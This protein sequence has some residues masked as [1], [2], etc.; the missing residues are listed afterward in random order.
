MFEFQSV[1][2]MVSTRG[3]AFG[4]GS[5][6]GDEPIDERLYEFITSEITHGIMEATTMIFGTIN[7]GIM[8]LLDERIRVLRGEIALGQ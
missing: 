6:D 4:S 5:G 8:E 7:E 1:L 2:I 3:G